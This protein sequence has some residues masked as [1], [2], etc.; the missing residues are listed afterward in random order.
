MPPDRRF[1]PRTPARRPCSRPAPHTLRIHMDAEPGRLTPVLEPSLWAHAHHRS[2]PSSSRYFD[3]CLLMRR[4]P[5]RYTARLA[6]SWRVMPGGLEIR[7]E[8]QPGVTFH[9]GRPLT[10]SDVQFTLDALRDPAQR[11]RSPAADARRRRSGRADHAARDPAAAQ[12]AE[13]HGCC[14]RSPRSRSCRCTIYDGSL[15]AGGALVG[16]GPWKFG[17]N[18]NG[19]VHLVAQ[20]QVLGRHAGDRGRR[21]RRRARCRGCAHGSQ[22]RRARHRSRAD[23]CALA[24]A[25]RARPVSPRRSC[26]LQ[27]APPRLRFFQ[28][29]AA[30][31]LLDDARVRQALS[32]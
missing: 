10:T 20:R 13:R 1:C 30:R 25:S 18:K 26:R 9:D 27:L 23:P 12:A 16:T 24:R 3:M 19:V 32:L 21:V 22:A 7:I 17:S 4:G 5:A 14:A 6:R 29:N 31:P 8:L 28:F 2:E 15:L 11:C